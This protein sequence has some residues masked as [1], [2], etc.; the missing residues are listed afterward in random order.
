MTSSDWSRTAQAST[1]PLPPGTAD[2]T[3]IGNRIIMSDN[4]EPRRGGKTGLIIVPV[5]LLAFA[6]MAIYQNAL[7]PGKVKNVFAAPAVTATSAPVRAAIIAE[8][9]VDYSAQI[10]VA[11]QGQYKAQ[12][13]AIAAEQRAVDAQAAQQAA[14]VVLIQ[15]TQQAEQNQI[16]A[17][18]IEITR[19]ANDIIKADKDNQAAMLKIE[20]DKVNAEKTPAAIQ[21]GIMAAK[22]EQDIKYN[23]RKAQAEIFFWTAIPIIAGLAVLTVIFYLIWTFWYRRWEANQPVEQPAAEP[24]EPSKPIISIH[25]HKDGGET[26]LRKQPPP[27]DD[28][29]FR[30]WAEK[31]LTGDSAAINA[32]ETADSPFSQK[33]YPA[34]YYRRVFWTW[35]TEN[36]M[37]END[38]KDGRLVLSA[39]G[40]EVC[41]VW[42][43]QHPHSPAGEISPKGAGNPAARMGTMT[44]MTEGQGFTPMSEPF[45][46]MKGQQ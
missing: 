33:N 46:G 37:V 40:R 28:D 22:A 4:F 18:Q 19:Q 29:T 5:I 2:R 13:T 41:Q 7:T 23:D 38:P 44:M 31:M 10:A 14:Q 8:P 25:E 34:K 12:L 45:P 36:G 30:E 24:N 21:N 35:I 1:R 32:W 15:I 6:A 16:I 3:L 39:R 9:T 43:M 11:E 42:I 27:C 26:I 20:Q 17:A